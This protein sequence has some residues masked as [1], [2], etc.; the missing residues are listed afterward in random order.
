MLKMTGVVKWIVLRSWA[1][2]YNFGRV[3]AATING[4]KIGK[5]ARPTGVVS[6]MLKVSGGLV[7]GG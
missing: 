2:L 5:T 1:Q 4:L 7:Q 6:E 3:V